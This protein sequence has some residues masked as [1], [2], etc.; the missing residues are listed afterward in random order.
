MREPDLSDD[1]ARKAYGRLAVCERGATHCCDCNHQDKENS[2]R[3]LGLTPFLGN[4]DSLL[5][6]PGKFSFSTLTL[7]RGD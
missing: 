4:P 1:R 3:P 6:E 5:K 7:S 2:I